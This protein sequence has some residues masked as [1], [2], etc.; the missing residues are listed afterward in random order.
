M[1]SNKTL[2]FPPHVE[3]SSS[4]L[5]F[6]DSAAGAFFPSSFIF[7]SFSSFFRQ[8]TRHSSLRAIG[9]RH[10]FSPGRNVGFVTLSY[11]SIENELKRSTDEGRIYV[12]LLRKVS[13]R[14]TWIPL[15]ALTR[16]YIRE[17]QRFKTDRSVGVYS[18]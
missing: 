10:L 17:K 5:F 7:R 13:V 11:V 9:N 1:T 2:L 18:M 15:S 12:Y 4:Y 3:K 16:V 6:Y 8:A 14:F